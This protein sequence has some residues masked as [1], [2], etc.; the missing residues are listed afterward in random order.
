MI[1][2]RAG[3]SRATIFWHFND[4]AALFRETCRNLIVPFRE[5]IDHE[6]QRTDPY[7]A[8]KEQV[9]SYERFVTRNGKVIR[10][11]ASWVFSSPEHAAWL[12]IEIAALHAD[13]VRNLGRCLRELMGD[14]EEAAIVAETLA[15][16]LH[17]NMLLELG[18]IP[19]SSADS[20]SRLGWKYLDDA[21]HRS[22]VTRD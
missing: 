3:V 8:I 14:R 22:R 4:K 5:A 16:L 9:E 10:A 15:S 1:A 11:F 7:A 19:P 6:T 20:R 17:G 12:Q 18:G 13:Y 2:T 21:I